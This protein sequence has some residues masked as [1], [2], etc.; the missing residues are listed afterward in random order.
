[1]QHAQHPTTIEGYAIISEN[2]DKKGIRLRLLHDT[3]K[4]EVIIEVSYKSIIEGSEPK[5]KSERFPGNRWGIQLG[6]SVRSV[7]RAVEMAE[8]LE[9]E[10]EL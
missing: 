7:N 1:M 3:G 10:L 2:V 9:K 5:I 6:D 4:H 8:E